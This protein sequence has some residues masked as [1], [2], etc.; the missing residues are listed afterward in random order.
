VDSVA[1]VGRLLIS[2]AVVLGLMWL[3]ARRMKRSGGHGKN[4][5]LIELL[6][7]QQ[8]TR[9]SS[10][11]VVRV[12]DQGLILGVTDGQ[13]AVLGEVELDAIQEAVAAN[14]T[15]KASRPARPARPA[16][17]TRP[18]AAAGADVPA[19]GSTPRSALAGSALSLGTW[20]QTVDSLRD[21]TA[22]RT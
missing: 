14:E 18:A 22:R 4:G 2:L 5:K 6:S 7:R 9:S 20:R 17:V 10:V 21:L 8:L 3:V 12:L 16:R 19:N 13:V 1:L 15:A 11:A